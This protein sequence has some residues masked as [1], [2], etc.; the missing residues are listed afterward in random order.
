MR[1]ADPGPVVVG[2]I[3]LAGA[4]LFLLLLLLWW[5]LPDP[6]R[7]FTPPPIG[8]PGKRY[9]CHCYEAPVTVTVLAS[10][11]DERKFAARGRRQRRHARRARRTWR[12]S[13]PASPG[14]DEAGGIGPGRLPRRP[15]QRYPAR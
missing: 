7:G 10:I 4:A 1:G 9:R 11:E 6:H 13:R 12:R 8:S 2:S 3:V 5:L 15:P 14:H